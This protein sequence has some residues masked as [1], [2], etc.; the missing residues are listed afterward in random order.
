MVEELHIWFDDSN[1]SKSVDN[2]RKPNFIGMHEYSNTIFAP[3]GFHEFPNIRHP[4]K[5]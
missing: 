4:A 1:F 5:F 3:A 2:A